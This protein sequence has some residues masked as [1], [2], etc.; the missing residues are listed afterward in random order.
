MQLSLDE[1]LLLVRLSGEIDSSNAAEL[2]TAI[3]EATPNDA[4]GVA[5]DLTPVDY[6]DSA[7]IHLLFRLRESL[8]ARSQ[9]LRV[10]VPPGSVVTDALRL[11]GV[12]GVIELNGTVEEALAQL[13]ASIKPT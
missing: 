3:T 8:R 12:Y 11:A 13:R 5:L 6:L 2:R 1:G 7:G 10:V 9:G 4:Y